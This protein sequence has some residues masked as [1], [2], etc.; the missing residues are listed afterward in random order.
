MRNSTDLKYRAF[1]SYAH[2]DVVASK[3]L[4]SKLESFR[5]DKDLVGRQ[6]T[7]GLVPKSLRP[8]F[9]DREDFSGGHTLTD[10]TIAALDGSAA[11]IVMCSTVAA[12]R[13]AVNEEVRL[14]RLRHPQRPVIPVIIEGTYPDNFPPALRFEIAA[15]GT[16]TDRPVTILGPDLRDSGDGQSRG[17]AKIVAGLTGVGTDEIVR[18][19]KRERQRRLR[20]WIA[21]LSAVVVALAGLTVWAEINRREAVQQRAVANQAL[22]LEKQAREHA[23]REAKRAFDTLIKGVD[24]LSEFSNEVIE[25]IAKRSIPHEPAKRLLK[26]LEESYWGLAQNS[27]LPALRRSQI[28]IVFQK[29]ASTYYKLG[30]RANSLRS[31]EGFVAF[32]RRVIDADPG[33]PHW[34]S[35]LAGSLLR[36]GNERLGLGDRAGQIRDFEEAVRLYEALIKGPKVGSFSREGFSSGLELI[37][38]SLN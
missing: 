24:Q 11:L 27:D 6:T 30:D 35:A 7:R 19:A 23:D 9:R 10:A 16:V 3:R 36:L 32:N 26:S 38:S 2:D 8:I 20:N 34:K 25:E 22:R 21:G 14:F 5:I 33:N 31:F 4:H 29:I 1:L 18:R 17:L 28:G 15:D 12:K 13:P 37:A